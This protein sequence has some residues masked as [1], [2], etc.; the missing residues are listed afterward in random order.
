M[1]ATCSS[2]S[3][4]C[5]DLLGSAREWA[6]AAVPARGL[7][8]RRGRAPQRGAAA[9]TRASPSPRL[10][11]A[12]LAV[13]DLLT[14]LGVRPD[15]LAGHSYGE[16][17]A[18]CAAGAFDADELLRAAARPR[19]ERDPRRRRRRPR[20]DGRR[21]GDRRTAR[22]APR[23]TARRAVVVANHNAPQQIVISGPTAPVDAARSRGCDAAGHAPGR[24]RWRARS[25]ARS[26]P[27][28]AR[29]SRAHSRPRRSRARSSRCGRTRT[30]EPY[31]GGA[32]R[33]ARR[34]RRADRCTGALPRADRVDVRRRRPGVRRG[35]ARPG[36]DRAGR[37]DP[38]RPP[39][40]RGGLRRAGEPGVPRFL[41]ALGRAR[42][43]RR[44]GRR[45]RAVRRPRRRRSIRAGAGADTGWTVDGHLV[46]TAD[47]RRCPARCS[48]ADES[49]GGHRRG[50]GARRRPA[51]AGGAGRRLPARQPRDRGRPARRHA[52]PTSAP[53]ASRDGRRPASAGDGAAPAELDAGRCPRAPAPTERVAAHGRPALGRCSRSY[54][55]RTG[56]PIDMLDPDLDLEAD[57]SIDS[58]KRIE[59]V[60]ELA[61]RIGLDAA[62]RVDGEL[63]RVRICVTSWPA[64]HRRHRRRSRAPAHHAP[65]ER[66]DPLRGDH[67]A[68][69][70]A[71]RLPGRHARARARPRSATSRSTPS[72]APR[73]PASSRRGSA[74]TA[75]TTARRPR[76]WQLAERCAVAGDST[77]SARWS[78]STATPRR[79]DRGR[80][81]Q[82]LR[83][84][85]VP[86]RP[87]AAVPR[88]RRRRARGSWST[89]RVDTGAD[90]RQRVRPA[91]FVIFG[92]TIGRRRARPR[93][94][95]PPVLPSRTA[96]AAEQ[97]PS[98]VVGT[99]TRSPPASAL[100][101]RGCPAARAA[102]R[103][104]GC[105][106][107]ARD[108]LAGA[109]L[110]GC[111]RAVA[112]RVAGCHG[113]A[114][115]GR[116]GPA[117][118][119][120]AA[121]A[122]RARSTATSP[123]EVAYGARRPCGRDPPALAAAGAPAPAG[124]APRPT[125]L[126]LD[127]PTRSCCCHRRRA[128]DHRP[129][130]A[131]RWPQRAAAVEL[132]GR[133]PLPGD[134]RT[135][136]PR[137]APRRRRLRR[138]LIDQRP[139][140][141]GRDRAARPPDPGRA[142]RS[143]STLAALRR[144]RRAGSSTTRSTCATPPRSAQLVAESTPSTAVWTAWC[145]RAGV[146]D[147]R[148]LADK[149]VDVVRAGCSTPRS[150]APARCSA[151]LP[152]GRAA[153]VRGAVRQHRRCLRQPGPGRLRGGQRRARHHRPSV[154]GR[155]GGGC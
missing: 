27:A 149:T 48:P 137:R 54:R 124:A 24:S 53:T 82:R 108:R 114:G 85:S 119:L 152:T 60:G 30:A 51:T 26:S 115:R 21:V 143:A 75:Q 15:M 139:P 141:P 105:W 86:V 144:G 73:S 22:C 41:L 104:R 127:E 145:T 147:D 113:R 42:G 111:V 3:R 103:A 117:D 7:R 99:S 29:A 34:A 122:R 155:T 40:R 20:D 96:A 153:P 146:I 134:A 6:D 65:G 44:A 72:S 38:R 2:P 14:R 132:V 84:P 91:G 66:A 148:L 92:A 52:A 36:P 55:E 93:G 70:R 102:A 98:T 109:R 154:G 123:V 78:R 25:T 126:G 120:A 35:R 131:S 83:R 39:A 125:A 43:R 9:P 140:R 76:P 151:A 107:P 121:A 97:A 64:A 1:L 133:T 87:A 46:R 68:D 23:S 100:A 77:P 12:G 112:Q 37:R 150:T 47:G 116:D 10:G 28:P 62:R 130:R 16:L 67:R 89:A 69:Q 63:D 95:P 129:R 142:A 128:R 138:A 59:I 71:H 13:H 8:R 19:A 79:G 110:R 49:T 32:D 90:G 136:A 33:V 50:R 118:P 94:S 88:P 80:H 4:G 18:L 106:S 58:I 17:V 31:P 135:R 56:Y 11:I 81:R 57:L 5:S 101:A 74:S 45:R 61:D